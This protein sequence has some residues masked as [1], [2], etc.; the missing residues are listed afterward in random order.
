MK[1]SCAYEPIHAKGSDCEGT[2]S[3]SYVRTV[4]CDTCRTDGCNGHISTDYN[5]L[6]DDFPSQ[7]INKFTVP[8]FPL[9]E[10]EGDEEEDLDEE[11]GT[12]GN[13]VFRGQ[14]LMT[15]PDTQTEKV[16]HAEDPELNEGNSA[17]K[18]SVLSVLSLVSLALFAQFFSH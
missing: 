5:A 14:K 7:E 15:K 9:K 12:I 6:T 13:D 4:F 1:R 2:G 10:V 16:F 17:E 3:P 11:D 8:S 18:K